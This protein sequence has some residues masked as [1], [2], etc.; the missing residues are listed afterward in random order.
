MKEFGFQNLTVKLYNHSGHFL[1]VG[2]QQAQT[3]RKW[4]TD[5]MEIGTIWVIRNLEETPEDETYVEEGFLP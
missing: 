4:I 1:Y 3:I 2:L 5:K